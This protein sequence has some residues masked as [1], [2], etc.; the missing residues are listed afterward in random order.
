[1]VDHANLYFCNSAALS[2]GGS[3]VFKQLV[4][5]GYSRAGAIRKFME[6]NFHHRQGQPVPQHHAACTSLS[7]ISI[8]YEVHNDAGNVQY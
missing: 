4:V 5:D 2:F 6:I 8:L 3:E 7:S 1:M